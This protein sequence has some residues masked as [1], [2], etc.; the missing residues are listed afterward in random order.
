MMVGRALASG[1]NEKEAEI[2]ENQP[3]ISKITRH[4]SPYDMDINYN[5]L[6]AEK[7]EKRVNLVKMIK[8]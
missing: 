1:K 5:S 4:V 8:G 3:E 7:E 6:L 2:L